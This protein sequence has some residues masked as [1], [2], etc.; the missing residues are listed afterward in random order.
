MS[1]IEKIIYLAD[2]IDLGRKPYPAMEKI[3]RS[4]MVDLDKAMYE[5]LSASKTYVV[6]ILKREV[7]PKTDLLIE[8]YR[9]HIEEN[10]I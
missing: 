8:E 6:N 3:R 1:A 10:D 2:M 7:H 4:A 9:K 5:A